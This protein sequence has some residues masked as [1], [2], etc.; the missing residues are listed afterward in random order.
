MVASP[1]PKPHCPTPESLN[2]IPQT[3]SPNPIPKPK[4]PLA[5]PFHPKRVVPVSKTWNGSPGPQKNKTKIRS[6]F[7]ATPVNPKSPFSEPKG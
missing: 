7:Q 3:Q 6:C 1:Y 4:A 5:K 2:G